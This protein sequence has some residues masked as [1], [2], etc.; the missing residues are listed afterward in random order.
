MNTPEKL[1]SLFNPCILSGT[2]NIVGTLGTLG[3]LGKCSSLERSKVGISQI[4][5][6]HQPQYSCVRASPLVFAASE[7]FPST[8]V[9]F[10]L[11]SV[12]E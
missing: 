1:S 6:M 12:L 5:D 8:V 10:L 3:M 4:P 11:F 9:S 7:T 2:R